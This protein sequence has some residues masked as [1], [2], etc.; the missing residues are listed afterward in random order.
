MKGKVRGRYAKQ[1]LNYTSEK[2]KSQLSQ[3]NR[4]SGSDSEASSDEEDAPTSF[5]DS[6]DDEGLF[7]AKGQDEVPD[8]ESK[9]TVSTFLDGDFLEF[10]RGRP[11]PLTDKAKATFHFSILNVCIILSFIESCVLLYIFV[12]A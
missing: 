6:V 4:S 8:S 9:P 1:N 10:T 12:Y 7:Y 5:R 2:S 11:L 3:K